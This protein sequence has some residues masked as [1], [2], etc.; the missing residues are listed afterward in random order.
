MEVLSHDIKNWE[1]MDIDQF[2]GT[3]DVSWS[4]L[5]EDLEVSN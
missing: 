1:G 5:Q 3:L 4:K 2:K